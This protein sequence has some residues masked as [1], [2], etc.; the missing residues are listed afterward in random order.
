M[1]DDALAAE[2]RAVRDEIGSELPEN[3]G[4][5][6][7]DTVDRSSIRRWCEALEFG[8]ELH[9]FDDI[10]QRHGFRAVTAPY[11]A[12]ASYALPALWE[13]GDAPVFAESGLNAQ[14]VRSPVAAIEL[15]GAPK[16]TGFFATEIEN[17]YMRPLVVGDQVRRGARRLIDCVPKRTRVG[18]GAFVTI[19][20]TLLDQHDELI[21]VNRSTYF[22]YRPNQELGDVDNAH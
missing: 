18:R 20:T 10:A 15:P 22:Y 7:V 8:C 17:Q 16:V 2:W 9:C 5:R 21:A 19:E 14:P 13:P 12:M 4:S 11:S 6:M 3:D 1:S